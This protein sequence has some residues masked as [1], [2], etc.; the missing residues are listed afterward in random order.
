[1]TAELVRGQ[2]HPV[3]RSRVEIRVSA[4]TPVLALASLADEQGRFSG[5]GILAHPGARSLPGVESP[6]SSP[7]GTPS[8]STSTRSRRTSTG[9]ASCSSCRP[10]ARSAS[11]RYRPP[12]W[13]WPT[14][15]APSS[16]DTP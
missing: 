3:S 6:G 13:P 12:T 2:N 10:A 11:A 16:P 9:S 5:N 7:T 15:R 4:G 1:M 14:R 8:P